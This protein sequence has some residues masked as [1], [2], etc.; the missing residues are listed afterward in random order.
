MTARARRAVVQGAHVPRPPLRPPS[1]SGRVF[2]GSEAVLSGQLSRHQLQTSAWQRLF[3]DIYAC[4]T[5]EVTHELRAEA[6]TT[7]LVPGA[8]A[9]G[10]TAATLWGVALA[11]PE[12]DVECTVPAAT[13]AG[14]VAGVRPNRLGLSPDD[15]TRRRGVPVTT[16]LRTALDLARIRPL[17]EAVVALDRFLRPGLVFLDVLRA[18]AE[19]AT[20]RDCR[21]IR[22]AV[23][24]ADGLAESPQETRVR[25][26]LNRSG[27]PMPVAQYRVHDRDRFVARVDFAWPEA[28]VAL[29]YDGAWHGDARQVGRDRRRLNRLGDAGW[30]VVFVTAADLH[31]PDLLFARLRRL[32]APRSA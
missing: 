20:G 6:V 12:D 3:A 30:I 7:L 18:A 22:K 11:S 32:L 10:R 1:L 13:G 28:K 19:L 26:L 27:L 24:L 23:A 29:E 15:V 4:T 9:S 25:L 16:P 5:L 21:V 8:V 17:D 14:S 2:R 31:R